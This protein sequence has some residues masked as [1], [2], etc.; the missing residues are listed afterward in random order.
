MKNKTDS[1][2]MGL[3]SEDAARGYGDAGVPMSRKQYKNRQ[4]NVA[5]LLSDEALMEYENRDGADMNDAAPRGFLPR[6][7]YDDRY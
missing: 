7:N 1:M 2:N 5:G 6:N 4:L 3:S